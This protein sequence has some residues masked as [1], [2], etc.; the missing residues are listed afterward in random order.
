MRSSGMRL[1]LRQS[2]VAIAFIATLSARAGAQIKAPQLRAVQDLRVDQATTTG[3]RS[4][5]TVGPSGE[6][7]VAGQRPGAIRG[8]DSTGKGC[9]IPSRNI[10]DSKFGGV[11]NGL[12]GNSPGLPTRGSRRSR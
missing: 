10:L 6:I 12:I 9:R 5:L 8:F 7:L 2:R 11:A 1:L 3:N 4:A